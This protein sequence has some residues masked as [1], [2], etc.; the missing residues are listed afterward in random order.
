MNERMNMGWV[1]GWTDPGWMDLF[2]IQIGIRL[3]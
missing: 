2:G 1:D 3:I